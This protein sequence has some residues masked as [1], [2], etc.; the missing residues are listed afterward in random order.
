LLQRI[1]EAEVAMA[2]LIRQWPLL[3]HHCFSYAAL[4]YL[5]SESLTLSTK[6]TSHRVSFTKVAAANRSVPF[7]PRGPK[8][9]NS[10]TPYDF[11]QGGN[12][13]DSDSEANKSRNQKKRE[14]RRSVRWGME[15]ASFS[16]PQIKRI[17]K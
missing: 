2:R 4:N 8:L 1:K 13:S 5:L 3:H 11:E 10:P 7:R 14:A 6:A 9:P 15:L 16:P 17:I 12:V